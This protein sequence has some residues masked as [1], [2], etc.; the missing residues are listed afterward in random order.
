MKKSQPKAKI[1]ETA[2]KKKVRKEK[3]GV[4][5]KLKTMPSLLA[6]DIIPSSLI[7]SIQSEY[8][9]WKPAGYVCKADLNKIK[10]EYVEKILEEEMGK[11]TKLEHQVIRSLKQHEILSENVNQ[12]FESTLTFGE[13]ISDRVASFGGSWKFIIS[14]AVAL[15]GWIL[16]NTLV[17]LNRGFD[18]YPF[19]LLNLVLSTLAAIQAPI[20]MMSQNRQ[21]DRDRLRSEQDY[22]VNLKAELEIKHLNEKMDHLLHY[23]WQRLLEIQQLPLR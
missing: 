6:V 15:F 9:E 19:I 3:C 10:S 2:E 18:P 13:R 7:R 11:L 8:P 20:I 21:E 23:Q 22:K 16:L 12:E 17:F 14:F 5:Y 1:T 4:C